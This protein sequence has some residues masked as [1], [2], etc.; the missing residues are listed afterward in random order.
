MPRGCHD[1]IWVIPVVD[2]SH[3]QIFV[4]AFKDFSL[5][6]LLGDEHLLQP[7]LLSV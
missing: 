2:S 3:L 1:A 4:I 6:L 7:G 5:A